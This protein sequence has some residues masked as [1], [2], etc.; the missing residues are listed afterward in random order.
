MRPPRSGT[1][2]DDLDLLLRLRRRRLRRRRR[3]VG[4]LIVGAVVLVCAVVA[5]TGAAV[6]AFGPACDLSD[7]KAVTIGQNSTWPG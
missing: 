6:F 5:A 1:R 2:D 4:L 3:P 7:L